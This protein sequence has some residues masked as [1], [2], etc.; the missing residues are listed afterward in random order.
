M[1]IR[2]VLSVTHSTRFVLLKNNVKVKCVQVAFVRIVTGS[3]WRR[4]NSSMA[5]RSL[6]VC[7]K[8]CWRDSEMFS[9]LLTLCSDNCVT[10]WTITGRSSFTS[11]AS[12]TRWVAVAVCVCVE[13]S[14]VFFCSGNDIIN[15]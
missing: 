15:G 7:V 2:Y 6:S 3:Y 1:P 5:V 10:L 11:N 14:H 4:H 13:F 9:L 12:D 8:V